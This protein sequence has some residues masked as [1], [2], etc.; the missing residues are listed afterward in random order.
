MARNV[1]LRFQDRPSDAPLVERVFAS[2]SERA[3]TFHSMATCHWSMVVTR[4]EG[5]AFLTLRGPET[6]ASLADCPA[7]GEWV[8]VHFKLG[9]FMPSIPPGR[10]RDRVDVTLPA[11][12]SR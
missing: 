4:H 12:S 1:F 8:G 2:T 9:A 5:R 6:R 7:G 3:G 10:M 11:A